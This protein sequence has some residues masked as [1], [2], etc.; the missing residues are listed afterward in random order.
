MVNHHGVC[1]INIS[2]SQQTN[3][4]F[5]ALM[6]TAILDGLMTLWYEQVVLIPSTGET[7]LEGEIMVISVILD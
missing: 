5:P 3:N 4:N 1:D 7:I 6:V 2:K